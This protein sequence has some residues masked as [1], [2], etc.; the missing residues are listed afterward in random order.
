MSPR[1]TCPWCGKGLPKLTSTV[2]V[3]LASVEQRYRP[4][5]SPW[6]RHI[7]VVRRPRSKAECEAFT[8]QQIVSLNYHRGEVT[9]FG[10][11]DGKSYWTASTPFCKPECALAFARMTYATGN[12]RS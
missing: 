10:E 4:P 5:D 2:W 12:R 11:W 3:G 8:D 7:W 9:R 1:P 6:S